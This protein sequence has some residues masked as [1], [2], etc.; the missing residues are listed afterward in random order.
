[1]QYVKVYME[2]DRNFLFNKMR[3]FYVL[4]L[5]LFSRK[6]YFYES[7]VCQYLNLR[8]QNF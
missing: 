5:N 6:I 7:C 1:M 4:K 2:Q 8:N 3:R